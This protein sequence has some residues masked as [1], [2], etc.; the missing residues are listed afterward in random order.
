MGPSAI[1]VAAITGI[2]SSTGIVGAAI[3]WFDRKDK[4]R[5]L[6]E[7]KREEKRRE[8]HERDDKQREKQRELDH[9]WFNRADKSYLELEDRC[10]KCADE[11]NVLSRRFYKLMAGL[12]DLCDESGDG[13]VKVGALRSKI[14]IARQEG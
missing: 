3:W 7:E 13:T 10:K 8:D 4:K 9:I 12:D 2:F 11:I 6:E 5:I 14:R 1:I